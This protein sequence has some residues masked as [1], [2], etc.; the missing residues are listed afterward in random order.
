MGSPD[1]REVSGDAFRQSIHGLMSGLAWNYAVQDDMTYS[2]PASGSFYESPSPDDNPQDYGFQLATA[3]QEAAFRQIMRL[4]E[5]LTQIK[6]REVT[7]TPE[8]HANIRLANT[9][10]YDEARA[11]LPNNFPTAGD[12]WFTPAGADYFTPYLGNF[13][14]FTLLHE[15]GH[16]LGLKHGHE[17]L[18]WNQAYFGT[19]PPEEDHHNFSVMTYRSYMG[20]PPADLNVYGS[21]ATS[22][23]QN[24]IAALQFLYGANFETNAEDTVYGWNPETG[25]MS[26]N[27]KG[28]GVPVEN[29][30]FQTIWDG[31][32][33]DT[34]DLSNYRS[35]V[36]ISLEPGSFST[37]ESGQLADLFKL[38]PGR[39]FADGNI[40]NARLYNDDPRSLI[41]NA[42]GGSGDDDIRGN[43]TA[44]RLEGGDGND[45]LDGGARVDE[46]VGGTGN[47]VLYS[48]LSDFAIFS[49]NRSEYQIISGNSISTVT[50]RIK[51]RDGTDT[52]KGWFF[53]KFLDG[54]VVLGAQEKNDRI[55]LESAVFKN[56]GFGFL[57]EAGQLKDAF[58]TIGHKARDA[59]D[60]IIYN[61]DTG[62]L[63]YDPDGSG[64]AQA[65]EIITL[66]KL[67]DLR[68]DKLFVI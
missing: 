53:A 46:L 50:D 3:M 22:Y 40:A 52:L 67:A 27:R 48:D 38:S 18:G 30:I 55:Y 36:R 51:G 42:I 2:L 62:S 13:G 24:D 6:V 33:N 9:T 65:M 49:G 45:T 43:A 17:E 31:N 16:A 56:A 59:D 39:K 7:E 60:F 61:P 41:E 15:V 58:F 44:N 68:A 34:Y 5:S 8:T 28:Q 66:S 10:L 29:K 26:I 37:F 14:F 25:E 35:D 20:A 57:T 1:P 54:T 12:I 21:Y 23:M 11:E 63:Y 64:A 32:G 4:V 19:L 47:D